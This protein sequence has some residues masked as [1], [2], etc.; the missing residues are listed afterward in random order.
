[1]ALKRT[2]HIVLAFFG[3][4][5]L[6]VAQ[7]P[8]NLERMPFNSNIYDDFTPVP[9]EDGM[10]FTSNRP[11]DFFKY[12][13]SDGMPPY[14]IFYVEKVDGKWSAA[15]VYPR[16]LRS[17]YYEGYPSLTEDGQMMYFSRSYYTN[18][19]EATSADRNNQGI[20]ITERQD[21]KWQ[22]PVPFEHNKPEYNL[23]HP[24]VS[25]DG[26]MLFFSSDMPDGQG[27]FDLYY[28]IKRG[29]SWSEPKNMGALINDRRDEI[30]PFA[31]PSGRVYYSSSKPG[32]RDGFELYYT[33]YFNGTWAEPVRLKEPFN[34]RYND[35]C[36]FGDE[37][38]KEGYIA[39][40]R[41]RGS[42]DIYYFK[43]DYP[44]F[45]TCKTWEENSY[46]YRFFEKGTMILDTTMFQYVWDLGDGTR[47]RGVTAEHCFEDTGK[48]T[49]SLDVIDVL[50]G[51]VLFNQAS[52]QLNVENIEQPYIEIPDTVRVFQ[53]F[54]VS[55]LRTE[56]EFTVENYFWDLGDLDLEVAPEF[57]KRYAEP[58]TYIIR[59]GVTGQGQDDEEQ[60]ACSY[61]NIVVLP[62][63]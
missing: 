39:S 17:I 48:Y 43:F 12:S 57:T 35:Y 54:T 37:E 18:K 13:G 21:N 23:L 47:I 4:S 40:D 6:V 33:E 22:E 25:P 10:L 15:R 36:F 53:D 27:R 59:L 52:Y 55:G 49:V 16:E 41:N 3:C 29:N 61:R 9:F 63:Q 5:Y 44:E 56:V 51:D 14:D 34:S 11:I 19:K 45:D 38:L 8:Y 2:L 28:C 50:T 58:G 62:S 26:K 60:K 1:M 31:H 7:L 32:I 24:S 30:F 20:F 46:C 42:V